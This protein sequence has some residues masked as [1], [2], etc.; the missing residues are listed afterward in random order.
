MAILELGINLGIQNIITRKYYDSDMGSALDPELRAG[1]LT[2]LEN[3]T[4]E[5]F[6]DDLHVVSLA[7]LKLVCNIKK[8]KPIDEKEGENLLVCYAI[9]E[10]ETETDIVKKHLNEILEHFLNRYS[11]HDIHHK[12]EKFFKKFESRID[13]ILGDLRLKVE[14]RFR[15]I[16]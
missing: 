11:I 14:D 10:K 5:V 8:L 3:F 13:S 4:T 6:G 15:S 16:F 2:A 9:V 1:F 7:S 12:K